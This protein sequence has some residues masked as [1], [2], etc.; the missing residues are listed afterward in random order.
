M[1]EQGG[2]YFEQEIANIIKSFNC[3]ENVNMSTKR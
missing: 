2:G 3:A 1:Y